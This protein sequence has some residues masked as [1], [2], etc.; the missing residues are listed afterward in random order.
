MM[1]KRFHQKLTLLNTAI[2]SLVMA[3]LS[4][5]CL[6]LSESALWKNSFVSFQQDMESLYANLEEQNYISQTWLSR[7]E[8]GG[9]RI[10]ILDNGTP[11]L[12]S[13][14]SKS[15]EEAAVFEQVL[16]LYRAAW[17]EQGTVSSRKS[18]HREF[19]F[20]SAHP[21]KATA[22]PPE[23]DHYASGASLVKGQSVLTAV[24]LYPLEGLRRQLVRQRLLVGLLDLA[25]VLILYVFS[26]FF[27]GRL[28]AP[29]KEN[30]ERQLRFLAASSHELRTPLAV[31]LAS[32]AACEVA[33]P[34]KQK[35]FFANIREEGRHMQQLLGE[36][37]AL[38]T[39]TAPQAGPEKH[40]ASPDTIALNAYEHFLP[41]MQRGGL[42]F[43]ILLPEEEIPLLPCNEDKLY[44]ALSI[45]LQNALSYTESDVHVTLGL[46]IAPRSVSFFVSDTGCG[47]PDQDK[48]KIFERFYRA[49]PARSGKDHFG[50]GLSIALDIARSHGGR[51]SVSDNQPRGSVFTLTLPRRVRRFRS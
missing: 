31:I 6:A 28:L 44:Q 4:L 1:W 8:S 25:G 7:M 36:L 26:R 43:E 35:A 9:N 42:S 20:D 16:E 21:E 33:P 5:L 47:I 32:A 2:T 15:P 10:Y 23:G 18:F 13:E 40:P 38:S 29:V 37:L 49:D 12:Y 14:L 46:A 48:K 17:P 41:L 45:L 39:G 30:Q 51:L 34:D 24:V 19:V 22:L 27:T 50:L 11:Y 3:A